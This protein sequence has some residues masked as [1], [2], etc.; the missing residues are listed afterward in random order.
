VTL[1]LRTL[2]DARHILLLVAGRS[3]HAIVR[4]ALEGPVGEDV[5]ASFVREARG[6]VTVLVDRAAW[7][8]E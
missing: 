4:R 8:G 5:P 1:G 3:K 7:E 2:L 6:S